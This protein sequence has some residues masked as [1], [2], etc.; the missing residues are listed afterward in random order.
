MADMHCQNGRG[1][2]YLNWASQGQRCGTCKVRWRA[3]RVSRTAIE[4]KRR[5][6]GR[7]CRSKT[8]IPEVREHFLT[9]SARHHSQLFGRL[10]ANGC[11]A[12]AIQPR[13][14]VANAGNS[15]PPMNNPAEMTRSPFNF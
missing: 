7:V 5:R 9:L 11:F 12:N 1:R 13:D 8:I 14:S 2:A 6:S 4:K 10:G 3:E 15:M